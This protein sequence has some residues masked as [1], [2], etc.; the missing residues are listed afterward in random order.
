LLPLYA[1]GEAS[2]ETRA[3]EEDWL[4]R[5]AA[6]AEELA[7]LRDERPSPLTA[8]RLS[9]DHGR[10]WI[11]IVPVEHDGN[12]NASDEEVAEVV[13]IVEGLLTPGSEWVDERRKTHP[14][15]PADIL[16]VAPY[17]AQVSRLQDA[18]T[19]LQYGA[20]GLQPLRPAVGTVDKFQGQEAP[21]NVATSRARG[22]CILVA[23]PRLFEPDCQTPAQIQLA[24]AICRH[25]ELAD[26]AFTGPRVRPSSGRRAR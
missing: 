5:D 19:R 15:T 22:L 18:L 25:K 6:L 26:D 13:R 10:A 12:R 1:A 9:E 7:A 8:A 4:A 11:R 14:L 21:V 16:I 23:N 17:N 2:T 3:L 20:Q 24:N